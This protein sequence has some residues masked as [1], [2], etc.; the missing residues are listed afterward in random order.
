[1]PATVDATRTIFENV[2][3]L[4]FLV[5]PVVCWLKGKRLWAIIGWVTGF[6]M[7]PALRLAK[8]DSWWAQ[9]FYDERKM[10]R[11]RGR[12][13]SVA[14][15]P[16]PPEAVRT[17]RDERL[18]R[19]AVARAVVRSPTAETDLQQLARDTGLEG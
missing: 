15:G 7:V 5:S 13:G 12:F 10:N 8:P 11:A 6:H 2:Y 18:Q 4:A 17:A 3:L 16:R 19:P 1:M 14:A 9:R